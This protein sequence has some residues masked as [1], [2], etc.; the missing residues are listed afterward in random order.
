M[1]VAKTNP[2]HFDFP[3]EMERKNGNKSNGKKAQEENRVFFRDRMSAQ[4][5]LK[6][7][8][9]ESF[10]MYS[11]KADPQGNLF[12]PLALIDLG[13]VVVTLARSVL[14]KC[15]YMIGHHYFYREFE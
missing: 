14:I 9:T 8:F 2:E 5:V 6:K 12:N 3:G 15:G 4:D 11:D 13:A 7:A 1:T 10:E